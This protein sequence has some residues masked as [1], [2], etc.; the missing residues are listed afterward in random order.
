M[1][2]MISNKDAIDFDTFKSVINATSENKRLRLEYQ[3]LKDSYKALLACE[4]RR[5]VLDCA[6][7]LEACLTSVLQEHLEIPNTNLRDR[8]L[9]ENNSISKKRNLLKDIGI[10]LPKANYQKDIEEPRN[11]AIHTGKSITSDRARKAYQ[12]VICAIQ[13]LIEDKFEQQ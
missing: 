7:A 3:L 4:Y 9:K 8:M 1:G 6:A 12:T 2:G 11:I 10:E 13:K 5:S